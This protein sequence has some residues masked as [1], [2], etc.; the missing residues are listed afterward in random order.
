M[1]G[2]QASGCSPIATAWA[3]E[4]TNI[5]PVRPDTIAKSLAIGNPADGYYA[6]KTMAA[7]NG[8][9]TSASDAQIVDGMKML[10]ECEGVFGETAGGVTIAGLKLGLESGAIDPE[11]STVA[12]ITGGGLKTTDAIVGKITEPIPI[13][14]TLESFEE[15]YAA[16]EGNN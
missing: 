13:E 1:F 2:A 8:G 3:N 15:A 4:T 14:G 11:L 10:A 7:T 6:L 9:A 5:R 16:A 12:F